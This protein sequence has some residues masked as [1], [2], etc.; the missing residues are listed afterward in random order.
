MVKYLTAT[1][2]S[3]INVKHLSSETIFHAKQQ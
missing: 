3:V 1:N 2:G